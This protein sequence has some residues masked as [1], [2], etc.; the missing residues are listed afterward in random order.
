MVN[1][2]NYTLRFIKKE[3]LFFSMRNRPK[4]LEQLRK[5]H[6]DKLYGRKPQLMERLV[7]FL[8]KAQI[9]EDFL[10]PKIKG[11]EPKNG[12]EFRKRLSRF[13]H[14]KKPKKLKKDSRI[15]KVSDIRPDV[16]WGLK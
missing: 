14:S 8:S 3:S 16:L 6:Y 15:Q 5:E 9:I 11:T 1:N 4:Q 13:A 2:H 10:E 12:R 7:S